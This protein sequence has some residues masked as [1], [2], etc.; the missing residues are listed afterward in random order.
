MSKLDREVLRVDEMMGSRTS[1]SS[2]THTLS[3]ECAPAGIKFANV[4]DP[5]R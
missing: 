1:G 2:Q 5:H 4:L 3:L